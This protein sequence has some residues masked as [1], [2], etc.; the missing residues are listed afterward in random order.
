MKSLEEVKAEFLQLI[1]ELSGSSDIKAFMMWLKDEAS[2]EILADCDLPVPVEKR[3]NLGLVATY[4]RSLQPN[5]E[6]V[7]PSE[8]IQ[9]PVNCPEG[10]LNKQLKVIKIR[11]TYQN[12]PRANL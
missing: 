4:S 7:C 1:G 11:K 6:A 12:L 10:I 5:F 3:K 2:D 8:Q 9:A